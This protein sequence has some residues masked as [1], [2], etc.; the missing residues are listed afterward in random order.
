M[1]RKEQIEYWLKQA[2]CGLIS[3]DEYRAKILKL[4]GKT[5]K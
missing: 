4:D 1:N 5:Y 2:E 3:W